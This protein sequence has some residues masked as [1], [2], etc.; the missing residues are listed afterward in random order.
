MI[1]S[2][3]L[4]KKTQCAVNA[5]RTRLGA[6]YFKIFASSHLSLPLIQSHDFMLISTQICDL[7]QN[8]NAVPHILSSSFLNSSSLHDF[9]LGQRLA[10][11]QQTDKTPNVQ[12]RC[13][14]MGPKRRFAVI[15]AFRFF[16]LSKLSFMFIN[17]SFLFR[18][19]D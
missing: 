1:Y 17:C 18:L 7:S 15:W 16:F 13:Q 11:C 6:H 12:C 2:S 14:M 4:G 5:A 3:I 10:P 19:L 8:L 9:Y